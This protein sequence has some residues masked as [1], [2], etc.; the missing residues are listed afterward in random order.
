MDFSYD[1]G[2]VP[3][4]THKRFTEKPNLRNFVSRIREQV[5]LLLLRIQRHA[6]AH[7]ISR[8]LICR[9]LCNHYASFEYVVEISV[10]FA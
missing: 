10:F 7:K 5:L 8:L 3:A 4:F 9:C 2:V 1:D 6:L